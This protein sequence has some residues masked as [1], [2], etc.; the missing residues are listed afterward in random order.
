[1]NCLYLKRDDGHQWD[2]NF[3]H[4]TQSDGV[5]GI[6]KILEEE[7]HKVKAQPV[8]RPMP[9]MGLL[10]K[11]RLLKSFINLTNTVNQL[12]K[13]ERL[14]IKGVPETF[15]LN[16]LTSS[17]TEALQKRVEEKGVS[18]NTWLFFTLD[19]VCCEVL[20]QSGSERKWISPINIRTEK[21][22]KYGNH[23]ASI[24]VNFLK[25]DFEKH[26]PQL[27]HSNIKKYLKANLHW[28]SFLYSNMARL[29]GK[30][31]T[32]KVAKRIKEVGTGVF[33]NLGI[34]P[35]ENITL[36]TKKRSYN[37]RAVLAPVT[38]VLPIAATAWQWQDRLSL[39]LQLHPS[40]NLSNDTNV[41][42]MKKWSSLLGIEGDLD[43]EHHHWSTFSECPQEKIV[44]RKTTTH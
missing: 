36:D 33:S 38:Q 32:L 34:W 5:G 37:R 27:L 42:V 8:T 7:G 26:S 10:K 1:M 31:G 40:L 3:I 35:D 17:Q 25:K 14:D 24:I 6:T 18:L 4:H 29:I 15:C 19:Q 16:L 30:R 20:L 12:W 44:L 41:I 9:A 11:F 39:S 22:K 21:I 43:I 13:S 28:G 2:H 23:S